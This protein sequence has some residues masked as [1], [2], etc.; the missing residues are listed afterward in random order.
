LDPRLLVPRHTILKMFQVFLKCPFSGND[1][2]CFK[3]LVFERFFFYVN[4]SINTLT[5]F[6]YQKRKPP[7]FVLNENIVQTSRR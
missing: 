1:E 4:V 5:I 7:N 2:D 6:P 3:T